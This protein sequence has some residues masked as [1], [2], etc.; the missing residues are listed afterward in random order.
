VP[1]ALPKKAKIAKVRNFAALPYA[2]IPGFMQ[3]L[4]DRDTLGDRALEFTILCAARTGETVDAPWAEIDL[5]GRVWSI[6]AERMKAGKLHQ[7]P[8]SARAVEILRQ[9]P[10]QGERIFP[11][12]E[13]QLFRRLRSMRPSAVATV[14]GFRSSFRDWAHELTNFSD[15][16]VEFALAHNVG[17]DTERSYKRTTLFDRRIKLMTA[18]AEYCTRPMPAGGVVTPL[19]QV[20]THD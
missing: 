8:L 16:V 4:R 1:E 9:V 13:R 2:D 10:R 3:E 18:W 17:D 11:I 15:K 19:R 12:G 20:A 7:V 6:P 14:H 5:D